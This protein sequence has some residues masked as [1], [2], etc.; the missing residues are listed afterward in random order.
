MNAIVAKP[1]GSVRVYACGGCGFNLGRQ[2][3]LHRGKPEYGFAALDIAYVD[4][5]RSNTH[6]SISEDHCYVLSDVDGSGKVRKENHE[7]LAANT[8]AILQQ[9]KPLDLNIVIHSAA[10]GTGSVI[11][12]LLVSELL[13]MECPTIVF[14]IGSTASF[15]DADNTHK[16]ILSYEAISRLRKASVIMAYAQNS[17]ENNRTLAD[18]RVKTRVSALCLLYSR[19]NHE[20]DSRDLF[21]WLR[22][23]QV[24]SFPAQL[25]SMTLF[26]QGEKPNDIGNII[27]VATLAKDGDNTVFPYDIDYQCVGFLPEGVNADLMAAAP[28]H[29]VVSDGII[30][31]VDKELKKVKADIKSIREASVK[32]GG[33]LSPNDKPTEGGLI[34]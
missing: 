18:S 13:E 21:N 1:V 22:P 20:L 11:G 24:T 33:L 5:S 19:Q 10:G 25:V 6:A 9:F 14:A 31:E 3:E 29:F 2:M 32:K 30:P 17:V 28:M 8:K 15:M 4:T 23:E 26:E 7:A 16:T 34:L 27:S 12:P